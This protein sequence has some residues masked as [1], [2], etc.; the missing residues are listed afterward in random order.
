M[1]DNSELIETLR[2]YAKQANF[3]LADRAADALEAAALDITARDARITTLE[4]LLDF[5]NE[6]IS[7]AI[8]DSQ[9]L[10]LQL[11]ARGEKPA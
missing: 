9:K 8:G 2:G 1:T 10:M 3:V 5:A 4:Q 7:D 6:A 11:S